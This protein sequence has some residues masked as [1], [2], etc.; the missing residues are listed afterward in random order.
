MGSSAKAMSLE[1]KCFMI[2]LGIVKA[3]LVNTKSEGVIAFASSAGALYAG[4]LDFEITE[5]STVSV[6]NEYGSSK[7]F[8]ERQL[9]KLAFECNKVKILIARFSTLYGPGQGFGKSQGLISHIVRSVLR[10]HPVRIF[11]PLSSRP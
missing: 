7:L 8:Q 4:C 3:K 1:N 6:I 10:N 11:V 5:E 9:E 2:F